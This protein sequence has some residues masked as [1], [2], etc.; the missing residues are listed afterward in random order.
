MAP[1]LLLNISAENYM[2]FDQWDGSYFVGYSCIHCQEL[3]QLGLGMRHS[4]QSL[5]R[6]RTIRQ[7]PGEVSLV[8][9]NDMEE[10]VVAR[11]DSTQE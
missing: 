11:A 7:R 5:G 1:V 8:Y 4:K 9:S 6:K 2:C 3:I 10:P